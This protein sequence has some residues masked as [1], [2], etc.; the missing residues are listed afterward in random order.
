MIIYGE[1]DRLLSNMKNLIMSL[2]LFCLVLTLIQGCTRGDKIE[3]DPDSKQFFRYAGYLLTRY[4]TRIFKN[5]RTRPE[6]EKFI[7]DFWEI[8]DPDPDTQENEF[9][10]EIQSRYD[11]SLKYL[12]ERHLPG[13]KTDRGMIY[14]VLGPPDYIQSEIMLDQPKLKGYIH[15]YYGGIGRSN[16]FIRFVDSRGDG[17]Y[18]LDPINTSMELLNALDELKYQV[19]QKNS[20]LFDQLRLK[21]HL[22]YD[23]KEA[24]FKI[25][26]EPDAVV[27]ERENRNARARFKVNLVVYDRDG[28]YTTYSRIQAVEMVE[29]DVIRKKTRIHLNVPAK[30][31]GG[32]Y[33]VD[34]L[35]TD[36]LAEISKRKFYN[37]SVN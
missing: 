31:A 16:L 33:K 6:R 23:N 5:L 37:V 9:K 26:V 7:R 27:F 21:F 35:V 17:I 29:G 22:E 2:I 30:L 10:R 19:L 1:K 3:L 15:W 18:H 11:F 14:I 36:L 12:K 28:D 13:W 20:Y 34:A 32:K 8:R 25:F 4:E 24:M